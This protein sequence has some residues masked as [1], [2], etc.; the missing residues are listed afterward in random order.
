MVNEFAHNAYVNKND[1]LDIDLL[2]SF[3]N[4]TNFIIERLKQRQRKRGWLSG[5]FE[6]PQEKEEGGADAPD[7]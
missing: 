6:R 3:I 7:L 5:L 2:V 4:V 1:G